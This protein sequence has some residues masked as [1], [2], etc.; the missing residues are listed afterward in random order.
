M[1]VGKGREKAMDLIRA[2]IIGRTCHSISLAGLSGIV[3][4]W[5]TLCFGGLA[6]AEL[7]TGGGLQGAV[8]QPTVMPGSLV[9]RYQLVVV[10]GH[11]A[12]PFLLDTVTGCIW[13]QGQSQETKR[14]VFLEVD[15]ENLHWSWGSGTQQ[16]LSSR[17]DNA[18]FTEEQK[19]VWKESLQRTSCG[20]TNVVLTPGTLAS[21]GAVK[22]SEPPRT[23]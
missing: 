12:S 6:S 2:S 15:V 10:P 14:T 16:I 3:A 5:L 8:T 20:S 17:V 11:T 4:L 22:S 18:S 9:G 13:Q 23:P 19:R 21:P 7:G 1:K